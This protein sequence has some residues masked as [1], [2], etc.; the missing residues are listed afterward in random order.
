MFDVAVDNEA[1]AGMRIEDL[2]V[3][4]DT[5]RAADDVDELVVGVAVTCTYPVFVEVVTHEHELIGV[6]EYLPL[7]TWFGG[8][9]L[10][11]QCSNKTHL[12]RAPHWLVRL[13]YFFLKITGRGH[14]RMNKPLLHRSRGTSDFLQTSKSFNSL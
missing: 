8:E 14:L 4:V 13:G 10:W 1:V 2:A 6:G 11:V 7:H 5:D 9:G 12:L 3:Y